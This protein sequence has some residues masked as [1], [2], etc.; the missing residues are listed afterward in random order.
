LGRASTIGGNQRQRHLGSHHGGGSHRSGFSARGSHQGVEDGIDVPSGITGDPVP[1]PVVGAHR[2]GGQCLV[3]SCGGV[4]AGYIVARRLETR[5][6]TLGT[7]DPVIRRLAL[8]RGV[9]SGISRGSSSTTIAYSSPGSG[10][11]GP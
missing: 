1:V 4:G 7:R 10:I 3:H 11:L 8:F 6:Q 9:P 5:H 2:C